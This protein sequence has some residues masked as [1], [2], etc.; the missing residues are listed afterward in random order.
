MFS[1]RTLSVC[2]A[3]VGPFRASSSCLQA[4][5]D[6]VVFCTGESFPVQYC[7]SVEVVETLPGSKTRCLLEKTMLQFTNY[8]LPFAENTV[9]DTELPEKVESIEVYHDGG[10]LT[11]LVNGKEFFYADEGTR[12]CHVSLDNT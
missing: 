12:D 8:D 6:S 2:C 11:L 7:E 3:F 10:R 1:Y 9:T 4:T 5:A